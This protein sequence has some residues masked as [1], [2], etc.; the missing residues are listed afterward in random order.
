MAQFHLF[1]YFKVVFLLN[2]VTTFDCIDKINFHGK[3]PASQSAATILLRSNGIL[4]VFVFFRFIRCGSSLNPR[5]DHYMRIIIWFAFHCFKCAH[6]LYRPLF[7]L[8]LNMH[9]HNLFF[10]FFF[11][12]FLFASL[13]YL[14]LCLCC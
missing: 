4:F 10:L 2:V 8:P 7:R 14:F 6:N 9:L 5:T 11:F 13:Y 1:I 3:C 12:S